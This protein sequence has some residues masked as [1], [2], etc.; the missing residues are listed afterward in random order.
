MQ[1]LAGD[2]QQVDGLLGPQ[3]STRTW[4]FPAA[5]LDI[6]GLSENRYVP[7]EIAI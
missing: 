3:T 1:C 5:D 6:L 2:S 4:W 7:N